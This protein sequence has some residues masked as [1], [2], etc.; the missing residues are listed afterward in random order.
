MLRFAPVRHR[1]AQTRSTGWGQ[2][3][4][5]H[6]PVALVTAVLDEPGRDKRLQ[7]TRERGRIHAVLL[8]KD[9]DRDG[10]LAAQACPVEAG[11]DAKLPDRDSGR[12]KEMV[13]ELGDAP[14]NAAKPEAGAAKHLTN[15]DIHSRLSTVRFLT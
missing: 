11:E 6:P 9:P 13:V 4:R 7:I 10:R 1:F 15:V 3:Q 5:P 14:R 2:G 8:G 12:R